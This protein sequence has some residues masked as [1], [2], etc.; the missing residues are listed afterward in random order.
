[1]IGYVKCVCLTVLMMFACVIVKLLMQT[2][3][4][5]VLVYWLMCEVVRK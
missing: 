2:F 3:R 1:M 4:L 5:Y